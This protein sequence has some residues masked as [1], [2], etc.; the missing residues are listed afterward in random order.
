VEA[1]RR[2]RGW[3]GDAQFSLV[4]ALV[5]VIGPLVPWLDYSQD[6]FSQ[7]VSGIDLNAG[8]VC[9]SAGALAVWLLIRPQGPRAAAASGAL[10]A[11]ALLAGAATLETL[12]KHWNDPVSPLWGLYMTGLAALALL[13]GSFLIQGETEGSLGPPD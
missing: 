11:L 6:Q 3:S 12:I 2:I 9:I 1:V 5:L 7:H 4:A 13:V 8:L 10:P